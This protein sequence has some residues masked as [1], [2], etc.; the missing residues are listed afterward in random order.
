MKKDSESNNSDAKH[1][2][3]IFQIAVITLTN[4]LHNC[5]LAE[6]VQS[7]HL[8]NEIQDGLLR[9]TVA[10]AAATTNNNNQQ[11]QQATI[12]TPAA[13]N[14]NNTSSNTQQQQQQINSISRSNNNQ[15]TNHQ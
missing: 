4:I 6:D 10:A 13:G 11:Q 3:P 5:V 14:N 8:S 2:S 15:P 12:S 9:A 7:S 1:A